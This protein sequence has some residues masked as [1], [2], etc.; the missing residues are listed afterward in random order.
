MPQ[1]TG[2]HMAGLLMAL[3]FFLLT[4]LRARGDDAPKEKD[5][6]AI[7]Q[8]ICGP[9]C[10][11]YILRCYGRETPLSQLVREMQWPDLARGGRGR[12]KG[13]GFGRALGHAPLLR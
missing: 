12:E 5:L 13:R 3:A 6:K 9:R 2:Y 4:G 7:N 1:R 10:V 8:V 11:Q